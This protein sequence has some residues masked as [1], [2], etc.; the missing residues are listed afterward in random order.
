MLYKLEIEGYDPI[1]PESQEVLKE[2]LGEKM[3]FGEDG[4]VDWSSRE[5]IIDDSI[6]ALVSL[7]VKV[8]CTPFVYAGMPKADSLDLEPRAPAINIKN[9]FVQPGNEL[10]KIQNAIAVENICTDTLRTDYLEKGW[11]I[12]AIC[13]QPNQRRPDY[14]L[15]RYNKE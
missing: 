2:I 11:M 14:I 13:P 3:K 12:L 4:F 6:L 1:S 15:G 10:L 9:H 8:K 7:H 5:H